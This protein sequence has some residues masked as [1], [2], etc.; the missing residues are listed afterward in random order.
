MALKVSTRLWLGFGLVFCLMLCSTFIMKATLHEADLLADQTS[1]ES[2]PF[3]QAAADMKLQAVQ[4][5]QFLSD[6]SATHET[7]GYKEAQAAADAFHA[8]ADKFKSMFAREKNQRALERI[9]ATAKAFDAMYA[10]GRKMSNAYINEGLEAGNALMT[11]FDKDTEDLTASLD[12]FVEEQVNEAASNLLALKSKLANGQSLQWILTAISIVVGS[13]TAFFVIR[14]LMLQLGA[15]PS[16]VAE[17]AQKIAGGNLD[18]DMSLR[19]GRKDCGVFSAIREMNDELKKSFSAAKARQTEV[20]QQAEAARQATAEANAAKAMAEKA[21]AEG[22]LLAARRLEGVVAI[23]TSVSEK[24]SAQIEQSSRGANQQSDQVGETAKS[25]DEMSATVLEVAQNAQAAA[26][27]SMSAKQQTLEGSRIVSTAV[28]GIKS[29][30]AQ[31]IAIKQ[32]MDALGKQ[33]ESIGQILGV[34]ADIADQTNLLALN[35]AIEAARAGDAG[36][37]FAVV[38]DEVRKLAEKTVTATQEVGAAITGIQE[39]TRK[40][41]ANVED[42]GTS[43]EQATQLAAQSGESL[44]HILEQ[45]EQLNEQIQSIATASEQQSATSEEISRSVGQVA[46]ISVET[47]QAMTQAARDVEELAQ[48]AQVLQGLIHDLKQ[49]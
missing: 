29:I 8:H 30:H 33:A 35:A 23:V 26:N 44:E 6:V 19:K 36:R 4:V 31:S 38:A 43:I 27:V 11:S 12:P 37:G 47:A 34:I 10:L 49:G 32:D 39:G 48:Q 42:A 40:N 2:V 46:A 15:E 14:S 3:A 45:V 41:I 18:V 25:M 28:T 22:M 16:D 17:V 1:M 7:D 5:Q 21:K 20:E 9:E 13:L 24:L